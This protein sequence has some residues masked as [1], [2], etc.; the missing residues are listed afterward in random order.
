MFFFNRS[1]L[2]L[3]LIILGSYFSFISKLSQ[4]EPRSFPVISFA[5]PLNTTQFVP[6]PQ[7]DARCQDYK[8]L[9]LASD[10]VHQSIP[11][12]DFFI[13]NEEFDILEIR[14]FELYPYV[15]LFLI[16]ESRE[17]LS[18]REKPLYLKENW[19][20]FSKYHDKIRRI[21]V[22]LVR[23]VKDPWP[24]EHRMRNEGLRLALANLTE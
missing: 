16:A 18:G 13:F 19:S 23:D 9:P 21:E 5:P 14:L 10:G 3:I 8:F 20:R 2:F 6:T 24:N 17:T 7:I 11:I 15:T 4:H 22:T 1:L 12:Y